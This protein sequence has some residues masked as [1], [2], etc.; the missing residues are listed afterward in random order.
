MAF[1][2]KRL[3]QSAP[4]N[5]NETTVYTVPGGLKTIVKNIIVANVTAVAANGSLSFVPNGG[6]VGDGNRLFKDMSIPANT[7]VTFDLS[8]VLNTGDFISIKVGT[9]SALTVTVSGVEFGATA[10]PA[11]GLEVSEAG[12]LVGTRPRINFIEGANVALTV[13]DD[14]A[15]NEVDVMVAVPV[16]GHTVKDEGVS[17]PARTGLNFIG[18]AVSV[19]DDAANDETEVRITASTHTLFELGLVR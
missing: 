1:I 11:E 15:N 10:L 17:L 12:T 3:A 6:A 9:A 2:P 5:T 14:G 7:A 18:G 19:V 4:A 16:A 8:Q 13:T